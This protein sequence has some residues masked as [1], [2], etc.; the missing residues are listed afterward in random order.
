MD[1]TY[2]FASKLLRHAITE[3]CITV[4]PGVYKNGSAVTVPNTG[5]GQGNLIAGVPG[6]CI[7]RPALK[8]EVLKEVTQE[9]HQVLYGL[10]SPP[11]ANAPLRQQ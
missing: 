6:A 3:I 9:L 1:K 7:G 8:M 4:D 2:P 10:N 11:Y 5:G